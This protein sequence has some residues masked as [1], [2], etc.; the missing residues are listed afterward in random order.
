MGN[1]IWFNTV[2]M[3][4]LWHNLLSKHHITANNIACIIKTRINPLNP[5]TMIRF[6]TRQPMSTDTLVLTIFRAM[7]KKFGTLL[8]CG[9]N[10]IPLPQETPEEYEIL[11]W[12]QPEDMIAVPSQV[13]LGPHR[14]LIIQI[15]SAALCKI[16]LKHFN[17][18]SFGDPTGDYT[19]VNALKVQSGPPPLSLLA[20]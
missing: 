3:Y 13:K 16:L 8:A 6:L 12:V 15:S 18:Y 20:Q 19:Y 11:E 4:N 1:S 9:F 2:T 7:R 17:G 10:R 14:D 5:P